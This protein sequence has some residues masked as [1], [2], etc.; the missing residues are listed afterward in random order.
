MT[1]LPNKHYS[2][3]RRINKDYLLTYRNRGRPKITRK[4]DLEKEMET[5][6]TAEER[7]RRQHRTELDADM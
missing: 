1:A 5:I 6:G 2:G 4:R 3:Y 7:W